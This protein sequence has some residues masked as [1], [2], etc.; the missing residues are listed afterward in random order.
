M[1]PAAST[2]GSASQPRTCTSSTRLSARA[3][4]CIGCLPRHRPDGS[5]LVDDSDLAR[6]FSGTLPPRHPRRTCDGEGEHQDCTPPEMHANEVVL[7]AYYIAALKIEAAAAER[8]IDARLLP[9][10]RHSLRRH[11]QQ[12]RTTRQHP[13]IRRQLGTRPRPEQIADP[14]H[15]RQPTV[16]IRTE[17]QP[18]TT[19]PTSNTPKSSNAYAIPTASS[20]N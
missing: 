2:S 5:P 17:S 13:R 8:G 6:K 14:R 3:H 9:I 16:V 7:L 18:A 10:P 11:F 15:S 12:R 19:T 20:R 4:S 1:Q